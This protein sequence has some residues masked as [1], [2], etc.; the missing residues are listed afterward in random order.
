MNKNLLLKRPDNITFSMLK[1]MPATELESKE[2]SIQGDVPEGYVAGW[3]STPDLDLYRHMVKTGAFDDSIRSRGLS[4]PKSVKLLLGHDWDKVSGVIRVLETR[5]GKLWIEAQLNLNISYARDAYEATKMAGGLNF[6]VG[7]MLQDYSFKED[8]NKDEYLLIERGDLFEVSIV[9]FPGNEECTMD[10]VKS[11]LPPPSPQPPLPDPTDEELESV[12]GIT[13]EQNCKTVAE[14][15]KSLLA[16]GLVKCR[17]D[18]HRITK[19]VKS[20][21]HLFRAEEP[22]PPPAV[23]P[24]EATEPTA[25]VLASAQ[26]D[27]LSAL[28]AKMRGIIAPVAS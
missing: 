2:L 17:R 3:A 1:F 24:P 10:V 8:G 7:F 26:V 28:V 22:V 6:S 18:A 14:F 19:T 9:P 11:R 21:V 5:Q 4:G 15:E 25:P 23:T 16:S 12:E 20:F 13:I 27:E